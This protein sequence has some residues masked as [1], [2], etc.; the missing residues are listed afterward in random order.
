MTPFSTGSIYTKHAYS[1]FSLFKKDNASLKAHSPCPSVVFT[2][3]L[4]FKPIPANPLPFKLW[5]G[6]A[7]KNIAY[8]GGWL[9][10][11]QEEFRNTGKASQKEAREAQKEE[12]G[13]E[14]HRQILIGGCAM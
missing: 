11:W 9:Y 4:S 13:I 14:K 2:D 12:A 7:A 6:N 3:T 1:F 10:G 8:R 5:P